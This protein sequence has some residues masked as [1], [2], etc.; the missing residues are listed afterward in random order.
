[1]YIRACA[2]ENQKK[3][4]D[5]LELALQAVVSIQREW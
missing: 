2:H 4:A 3:E 5:A 1:M